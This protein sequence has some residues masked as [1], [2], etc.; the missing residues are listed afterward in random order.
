MKG[1][2]TVSIHV[3]SKTMYVYITYTHI[4]NLDSLSLIAET[5]LMGEKNQLTP[6]NCPLTSTR[7]Y[8]TQTHTQTP[9]TYNKEMCLKLC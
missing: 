7:G 9:N 5:Y 2:N 3:D 4:P 6:T 1:I 8:S